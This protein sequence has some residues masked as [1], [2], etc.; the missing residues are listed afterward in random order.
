MHRGATQCNRPADANARPASQALAF[1]MPSALLRLEGLVLFVAAIALYSFL[2]FGWLA[3]AIFLLAPDVSFAAYALDK[4][5]GSIAYNLAHFS[6]LPVA[7]GVFSVVTGSTFGLQVSLIW[8]AH[9]N[10]DRVLGYGYKYIGQ[11]KETHL[12]RV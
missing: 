12:Q 3:F 8:F 1:S 9:I 2:G 11:F 6:G 10:M 5:A 7:I 4:R